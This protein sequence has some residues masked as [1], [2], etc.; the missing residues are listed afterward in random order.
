MDGSSP[1]RR[2]RQVW[3]WLLVLPCIAT[4]WVPFYGHAS[5]T[6]LG[7]PFFYW[8]LFLWVILSGL[9]TGAVYLLTR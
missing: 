8:Y 7:M 5:P 3:L 9:I 6:L 2:S 4:V 1:S